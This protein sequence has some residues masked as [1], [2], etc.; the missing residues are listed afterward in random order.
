M[1][2]IKGVIVPNVNLNGTSRE[3]L[4]EQRKEAINAL[5]DALVPLLL[6]TP[7][8]RDYPDQNEYRDAIIIH[9]ARIQ[10]INDIVR[11]LVTE[12]MEIAE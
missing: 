11:E 3:T 10:K 1:P 5:N 6:M 7:H 2:R 9:D 4:V 8:L 12:A